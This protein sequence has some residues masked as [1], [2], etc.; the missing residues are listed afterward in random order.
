[1]PVELPSCR[2]PHEATVLKKET[3]SS[4]LSLETEINQFHL[5]E[6]KEEQEELVIQVSNLEDELDK[7]FGVRTPRFIVAR[8]DNRGGRRRNGSE[9]E[10]GLV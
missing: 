9:Q 3:A 10:E 5:E 8:V 1:M 2:S 4:R 7:S 6:E